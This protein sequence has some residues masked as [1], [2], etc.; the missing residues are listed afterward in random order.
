MIVSWLDSKVANT[1]SEMWQEACQNGNVI[2]F[3]II[4]NSM[5]PMIKLGDVVKVSSVEPSRICTGD[6]IAFIDNG[7]IIVHRV[8]GIFRHKQKLNF[9]HRGDAGSGSGIITL[10]SLI[11]RVIVIERKGREI[12][13]DTRIN[14]ITSKLLGWRLK[15]KD[16][17]DNKK[18]R[19]ISN[20]IY[21]LTKPIWRLCRNFLFLQ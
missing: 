15:I 20:G 16:S 2:R 5:N 4:S 1:L 18:Y 14:V 6:I 8:I 13:L 17:L 9:R 21:L 10:K 12:H 11:G 19:P 3:K 7:N